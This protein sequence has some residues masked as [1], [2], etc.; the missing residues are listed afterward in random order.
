MLYIRYRI[1]ATNYVS[2]VAHATE[3]VVDTEWHDDEESAA[4]GCVSIAEAYPD[5][6]NLTLAVHEYHIEADEEP[7]DDDWSALRTTRPRRIVKEQ[8]AREWAEDDDADEKLT[9]S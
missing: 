8:T 4:K 3:N 9:R 1:D 7:S 5:D 6:D 2:G